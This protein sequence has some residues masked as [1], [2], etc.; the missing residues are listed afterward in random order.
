MLEC[1]GTCSILQPH[2]E[3]LRALFLA[4]LTD[5]TS[6]AIRKFAMKSIGNLVLHSPADLAGFDMPGLLPYIFNILE[7][8]MQDNDDETMTFGMDVFS[9]MLKLDSVIPLL[10]RFAAEKVF[11]NSNLEVYTRGSAA[12]FVDDVVV[13]RTKLIQGNL[14]MLNWVIR[15]AL[16]VACEDEEQYAAKEDTPTD[17]AMRLLDTIS[18]AIPNKIIFTPF[19]TAIGEY[20]NHADGLHRKAAVLAIG[21]MSEGCAE[22]M[23]KRL[24][25]IV[26]N[27]ISAF[28]DPEDAV[29]Q[30]AGLTTGY[31]AMYLLPQITDYHAQI[32]PALLHALD[33]YTGKVKQK[34]LYAIDTFCENCEHEVLEYLELLVPKLAQ[35]SSEGDDTETKSMA[36]SALTSIVCAAD[37]SMTPYF[38]QLAQFLYNI[39][40]NETDNTLKAHSLQ[41]LGQ[42]AQS[43]GIEKFQPYQDTVSAIAMEALKTTQSDLREAAFAYFY[44]IANILNE[45]FMQYSDF[46]MTQAFTSCERDEDE[47]EED[48]DLED[49]EDEEDEGKADIRTA[50]LDEKTAAVHAIGSTIKACPGKFAQYATQVL[51]LL[52]TNWNYYHSNVKVQVVCTYELIV[53]ALFNSGLDYMSI[54]QQHMEGKMISALEKEHDNITVVRCLEAIESLLKTCGIGLLTNSLNAIVERVELLLDEKAPCQREFEEEADDSDLDERLM[55]AVVDVITEI[56]KKVENGFAKFGP[57]MVKYLQETRSADTRTLFVGCFGDSL[58]AC[59]AMVPQL[60]DQILPCALSNL[61]DEDSSMYRNTCYCIRVLSEFGGAVIGPR[62]PEILQYLWKVISTPEIDPATIDNAISAVGAM[63]IGYPVGFPYESVL[64]AWFAQLPLKDDYEEANVILRTLIT[65][66][67]AQVNL[68]D[69][70]E[71]A[72]KLLF[73]GVITHDKD[74]DKYKLEKVTIDTIIALLKAMQGA[75]VFNNVGSQITPEEQ[76][77]IQRYLA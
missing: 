7:Q 19:M 53:E 54:W 36:V 64:P 2:L 68:G 77:L 24:D 38:D 67:N 12:D 3:N 59:P 44:S 61:N 13:G 27:I 34:A 16:E 65:M 71:L 8:C 40:A 20:R 15:V 56:S 57:K 9:S 72:V 41:C 1:A 22:P 4:R 76:Q 31:C 6:L 33:R 69:Y 46:V 50:I 32:L 25:E 14:E 62:A 39:I 45:N 26:P 51:E 11:A 58:K 21:I 75:E 73:D 66:I 60:I 47:N 37:K 28:D 23:K 49:S 74:P 17:I 48:S 18:T 55:T 52:N 29:K 43:S 30:A 10:V 63:I 42:L 35:T 70:N 5:E